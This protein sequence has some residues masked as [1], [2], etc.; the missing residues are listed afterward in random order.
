MRG[1]GL[2]LSTNQRV[3]LTHL[4]SS[5]SKGNFFLHQNFLIKVFRVFNETR[6]R[7]LRPVRDL[8]TKDQMQAN[9]HKFKEHHAF[10]DHTFL[11]S[12]D[13]FGFYT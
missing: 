8:V 9:H 1:T 12:F 5:S 11:V 4:S 2:I 7:V 3:L 6:E 13:K 10:Y